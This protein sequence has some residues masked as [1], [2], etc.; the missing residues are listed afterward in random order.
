MPPV[1]TPPEGTAP[2]PT[3]G[4]MPRASMVA[5]LDVYER[6]FAAEPYVMLDDGSWLRE[7]LGR[8]VVSITGAFAAHVASEVSCPCCQARATASVEVQTV[9]GLFAGL[10]QRCEACDHTW[11]VASADDPAHWW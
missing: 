10:L 7:A 4:A 5:G 11:P 3:T 2:A 1:L 8:L 6:A 9:F